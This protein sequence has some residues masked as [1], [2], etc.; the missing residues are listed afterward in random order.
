MKICFKYPIVNVYKHL[1]T[2]AHGFMVGF[3]GVSGFRMK[4]E[5]NVIRLQNCCKPLKWRHE[6]T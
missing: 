1:Q 5:I 6:H 2:F 4:G 3:V